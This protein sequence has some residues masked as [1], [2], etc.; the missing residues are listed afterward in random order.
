MLTVNVA[1]P[2]SSASSHVALGLCTAG[3]ELLHDRPMTSDLSALGLPVN[4]SGMIGKSIPSSSTA[5]DS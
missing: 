3:G 1:L 5:S 4:R 2:S